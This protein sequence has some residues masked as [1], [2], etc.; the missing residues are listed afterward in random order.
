MNLEKTKIALWVIIFSVIIL[1]FVIMKNGVIASND[2][3]QNSSEGSEKKL[4]SREK[5]SHARPRNIPQGGTTTN[6][7]ASP[8]DLNSLLER[9]P[10]AIPGEGRGD[11]ISEISKIWTA[12]D[13]DGCYKWAMSLTSH[14]DRYVALLRLSEGIVKSGNIDKLEYFVGNT[15]AGELRDVLIK[16]NFADIA[17]FDMELALKFGRMLS[18]SGAASSGAYDLAQV[19]LQNHESSEWNTVI[20]KLD[21]GIFRESLEFELISATSKTNP[22][23]ALN[24]FNEFSPQSAQF[25]GYAMSEIAERLVI[26]DAQAAA[27]FIASSVSGDD[28]NRFLQIL[29]KRWALKDRNAT[30]NWL[31]E[32]STSST[33]QG[34]E[35]MLGGIVDSLALQDFYGLQSAIEK[36]E[37][38]NIK[39]D[40]NIASLKRYSEVDPSWVSNELHR[41]NNTDK[42]R[43]SV[44]IAHS[45]TNWL[46]KDSNAASAWVA[47]LN[48]GEFRDSAIKPVIANI[49]QYGGDIDAAIDWASQISDP[50]TREVELGRL[51]MM[52]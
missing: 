24:L 26:Q 10:T 35:A 12:S 40:L 25:K 28:K 8:K 34:N 43:T 16:Q 5:L 15:P 44:S 20:E 3:I 27:G 39:S 37:D 33:Y 19:L 9:L 14:D 17:R 22:I 13:P 6:R 47:N 42:N 23:L 51:E 38:P 2:E 48:S 29:G 46:S 50:K 21:Y 45:V 49:L 31:T 32:N 36:I 30:M 4:S 18:G 7:L 41:L 52:K 1:I 11:L